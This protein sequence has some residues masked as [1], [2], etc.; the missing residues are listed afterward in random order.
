MQSVA[1]CYRRCRSVRYDFRAPSCPE[2]LD[3]PEIRN[4]PE[5]LVIW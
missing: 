2:I 4:C 5:I 3:I 1:V